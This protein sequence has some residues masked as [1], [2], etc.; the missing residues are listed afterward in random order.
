MSE[1]KPDKQ[2]VQ[3]AASAP[4]QQVQEEGKGNTRGPDYPLINP[5]AN[6]EAYF[7]RTFHEMIDLNEREEREESEKVAYILLSHGNC[8]VLYRCFAHMVSALSS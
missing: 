8:P 2:P 5:N 7:E 1:A 6:L 4:N 3:K